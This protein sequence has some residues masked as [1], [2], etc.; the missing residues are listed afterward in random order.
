MG[1]AIYC[2]N[3]K[4]RGRM[5]QALMSVAKADELDSRAFHWTQASRAAMQMGDD[6]ILRDLAAFAGS[7]RFSRWIVDVRDSDGEDAWCL[8]A[9]GGNPSVIDI[10]LGIPE[11]KARLIAT[12][13]S[14]NGLHVANLAKS[15]DHEDF[16]L[17]ILNIVASLG[18][19][20]AIESACPSSNAQCRPP[21]RRM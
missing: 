7:A 17:A 11:M 8:S 6:G 13:P 15:L 12:A 9:R 21:T 1:L 4:H 16:A 19:L 18:E 5:F 3:A 20:A 2:A 14:S 10:L